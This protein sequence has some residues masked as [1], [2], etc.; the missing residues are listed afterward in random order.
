[1]RRGSWGQSA[2]LLA[3]IVRL[4]GGEP[5]RLGATSTEDAEPSAGVVG[6]KK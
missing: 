3:A 5:Q 1:M 6:R 4:Q 2:K